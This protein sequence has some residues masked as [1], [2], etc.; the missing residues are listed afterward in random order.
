MQTMIVMCSEKSYHG[1][2]CM[3]IANIHVQCAVMKNHVMELF[4]C[5][6]VLKT[7]FI[8]SVHDMFLIVM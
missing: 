6:Q 5:M 2:I 8:Q 4:A 1:I 3:Q 7:I